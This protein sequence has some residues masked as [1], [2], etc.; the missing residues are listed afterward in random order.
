MAVSVGGSITVPIGMLKET[1]KLDSSA[2]IST[3][4]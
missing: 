2:I 1:I 3:H 4:P